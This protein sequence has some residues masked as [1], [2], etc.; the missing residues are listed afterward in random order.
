MELRS[1]AFHQGI[2]S[3]LLIIYIQRNTDW[4]GEEYSF[5]FLTKS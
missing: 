2:I 4:Q 3:G 5:F 1:K